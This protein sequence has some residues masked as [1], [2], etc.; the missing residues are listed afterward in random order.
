MMMLFAGLLPLAAQNSPAG[1]L[2]AGNVIN[3]DV[4]TYM[5][6][7]FS[8]FLNYER[9]FTFVQ[10]SMTNFSSPGLSAGYATKINGY[11]THFYLNTSGFSMGNVTENK[12]IGS[13][14]SDNNVKKNNFNLQFDTALGSVDLGTFKLGL[15]FSD[16]GVNENESRNGDD[17]TR[18]TAKTGFF[19]P[20]LAYGGNIINDDYSM[21]LLSGTVRLRLPMDYGRTV[22]EEKDGGVTTTTTKAPALTTP[23]VPFD[24]SMRLEVEPQ[25]WYFFKPQLEPMVVISHIYLLNTFVM[26]FYPEETETVQTTGLS[27][28]YTRRKHDYVGNT[29]F[30]YY[31]RQY[32]INSRLSL[33]WRVN[34]SVGF[35]LDKNGHTFKKAP[36]ETEAEIKVTNEELFLTATVAPRLAFSYQAIPATLALNGAVVF[37]QLGPLNAIGWQFY[38]NKAT[39]A[40]SDTV[41]TNTRNIFNP[42]KPIFTA[43]AAW[44][45]NPYLI[46]EAGISVNTSSEDNFLDNISIGI[47]Y[48][49]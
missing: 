37:N 20:S 31:N 28:G 18:T 11:F 5:M 26:M 44:N 35:Y 16:I 42:I 24:A 27:D 17:F 43:G 34:F 10:G 38:Q 32:V 7:N 30:G 8:P 25:M 12:E 2:A 6:V 3:R 4:D 48:K 9:F 33:A 40:D 21:M 13:G 22:T 49:R 47:V 46:L 14:I 23:S 29:L 1:G 39:D 36:G 41:T 45:L 19:T 15:L